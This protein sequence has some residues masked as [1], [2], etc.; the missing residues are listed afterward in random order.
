MKFAKALETHRYSTQIYP[1]ID[2][3]S[4]VLDKPIVEPGDFITVFSRWKRKPKDQKTRMFMP[5]E[6]ARYNQPAMQFRRKPSRILW[7]GVLVLISIGAVVGVLLARGRPVVT[8]VVPADN[9][10][11]VS[12]HTPLQITFSRPMQRESVAEDLTI[13]PNQNGAFS[14]EENTLTFTP[15]ESWP[16]GETITV[17]LAPGARAAAGPS[18]GT[19]FTWSFRTARIMLGYLWPSEGD[20]ELYALDLVSGESIQL[21]DSPGSV[22]DYTISPDGTLIYYTVDQTGGTTSIMRLDRITG[23]NVQLVACEEALCQRPQPSPGGN[24]LVYE[25]STTTQ[26]MLVS[27]NLPPNPT[28]IPIRL[29]GTQHPSWS[30]NGMLATYDRNQKAYLFQDIE[31]GASQ[32]FPNQTGEPGTWSPDGRTFIA[33]EIIADKASQLIRYNLDTATPTTTIL[34]PQTDQ[35][36]AS[37]VYAPDGSLIVYAHRYLD[38]TRW[39]RGRQIW[40]MT[41]DG[42]NPQQLTDTPLYNHSAFAWHPDSTQI[43]YL[44]FNQATLSEPPEIWW[45]DIKGGST[46]RLVIDGVNPQWLP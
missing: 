25:N 28:S 4:L 18:L 46:L 7:I 45:L 24:A 9:A 23:E 34:T 16:G 39:T 26:I 19:P 10:S 30:V 27:L 29:G 33:A 35:E 12:V 11:V 38:P 43:A 42:R 15:E 20:S 22:Q 13:T 5:G 21:T 6:E 44:R 1:W 14:W 41:A 2:N 36:F 17:T 3:R 31:T 37:P 32:A 40:V 8:S